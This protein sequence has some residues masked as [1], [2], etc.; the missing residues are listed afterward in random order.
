M[1]GKAS[2]SR[3]KHVPYRL[4]KP[5]HRI[6]RALR[7][8]LEWPQTRTTSQHIFTV[9][10]RRCQRVQH[11]TDTR[12]LHHV[13]PYPPVHVPAGPVAHP[14]QGYRLLVRETRVRLQPS[15][16][17]WWWRC[18]NDTIKTGLVNAT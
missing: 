15:N 6:A 8:T 14:S 4:H 7:T 9:K 11:H 10:L 1:K 16:T 18:W 12:A 17:V 13:C 3:A 5:V 2:C